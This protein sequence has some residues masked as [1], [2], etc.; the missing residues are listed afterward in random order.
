MANASL[1]NYP[2]SVDTFDRISDLDKDS[3]MIKARQYKSYINAGNYTA[4][5][6]YLKN[7]SDLKQCAIS[8]EIV[9]KHSDAIVAI[10]NDINNN[11]KSNIS[12]IKI[13]QDDIDSKVNSISSK[14]GYKVSDG[15]E[16]NQILLAINENTLNLKS[17][18][19]INIKSSDSDT[20]NFKYNIPTFPNITY[21]AQA[22]TSGG[23]NKKIETSNEFTDSLYEICFYGSGNNFID[24]SGQYIYQIPNTG[25]YNRS[26]G[27][28]IDNYGYEIIPF[29][30][31]G[32]VKTKTNWYP[33]GYNDGIVSINATFNQIDDEITTLFLTIKVKGISS[34]DDIRWTKG[35]I[36]YTRETY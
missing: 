11:V 20:I 3:T 2:T 34:I 35:I 17:D 4:A 24:A 1:S 16:E 31:E 21:N 33:I 8:A 22:V 29:S 15:N 18:G 19:R 10:E 14:L 30:I 25:W 6:N 36:K 27:N 5:E 28:A 13:K 7:N 12:D 9:N 26:S 32:G 23:L